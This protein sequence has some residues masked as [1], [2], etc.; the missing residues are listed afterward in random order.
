MADDPTLLATASG[1][2]SNRIG[3]AT[4]PALIGNIGSPRRFNYTVMG[5]TVNL[6]S[7][8]EGAN[9]YYNTVL[10]VS[11]ETMRHHGE[12]EAFRA[13]DIVQVVGRSEPVEVFEPLSDARRADPEDCAQRAAYATALDHWRAGRFEAAA[14][15]FRALVGTDGAA[16][17]M[18]HK[19]E[20]R[21]GLAPEPDWAGVTAL[22]DK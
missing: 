7:R 10:M 19:A 1:R 2:G 4:G 22:T 12:P 18:L 3:I 11:G 20:R 9:K 6:A 8:L 21:I 16:L 15:G 13:L 17:A 14:A 5:D